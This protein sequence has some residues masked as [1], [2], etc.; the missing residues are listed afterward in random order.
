MAEGSDWIGNLINWLLFYI[1]GGVLVPFGF[2]FVLLGEP[3]WYYD[4]VTGL[5]LL[6]PAFTSYQ[7]TFDS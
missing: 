4:T 1:I 6:P 3:T 5:N 2:L 7:L